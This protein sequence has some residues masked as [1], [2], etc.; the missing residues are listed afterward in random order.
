M[1][2]IIGKV[3]EIIVK[4]QRKCPRK[5]QLMKKK[6]KKKKKKRQQTESYEYYQSISDFPFFDLS[7]S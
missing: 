3:P 6:K 1:N 2:R 5:K 7:W 4:A